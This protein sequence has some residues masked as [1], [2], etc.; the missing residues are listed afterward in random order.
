MYFSYNKAFKINLYF[1]LDKNIN[2][3]KIY[4]KIPRNI[5]FKI[6]IKQAFIA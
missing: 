6:T 5:L 1:L 4:S 3:N 2:I